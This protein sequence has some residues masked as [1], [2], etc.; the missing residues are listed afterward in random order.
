MYIYK[1]MY[2]LLIL[3]I[4]FKANRG[5]NPGDACQNKQL[6]SVPQTKGKIIPYQLNFHCAEGL[7][8]YHKN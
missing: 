6:I 3:P 4:T 7:N 2:Y 1:V 5:H 8:V